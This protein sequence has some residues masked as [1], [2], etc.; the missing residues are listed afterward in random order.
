MAASDTPNS[1][2]PSGR[3][4]LL[5]LNVFL[6]AVAAFAIVVMTNYL[7]AGHF[8]RFQMDR[9]SA[10]KISPQTVRVLDSLTNNV[11]ITIFFAPHG[12]NEDLYGLVSGLLTEYQQSCPRHLR[13]KTLD[14]DRDVGDAKEFLTTNNITD[15]TRD[16]VFI[17][18]GGHSRLI[19]ARDLADYDF[20][21]LLAHRSKFVRRSAFLG[22]LYFTSAIYNVCNPQP[23]KAYFLWGN[24]ENDPAETNA[25]GGYSKLA[26]ILKDEIDCPWEK[27]SL[28]GTNEIPADCQLLIVPAGAREDTIPPQELTKMALYLKQGGRLF[29]LL[30]KRSGMETI[31]ADWG[32]GL[33]ERRA[34]DL[35]KR[36][37]L[38]Q[39]G[40][41]LTAIMAPHPIMNPL[42]SDNKAVEM[43]FPRP[44]YELED[45]SKI[46][47]GPQITA[48]AATS[49]QGVLLDLHNPTNVIREKNIPLLV[50]VEQG[51]ISG[52]NTAGGRGTRMVVAGD[53]DFL[54]NQVIDSEGNHDF[55]R[56]AL[57]WL[58]QRPQVMLADLGPRPIKE[59]K[60]HMTHAQEQMIGALFLA[61]MPGAVLLVGG[62][63]WL[64]RRN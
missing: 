56:L 61:G 12:D 24:G 3:R 60:L 36:F 37:S 25:A 19:Q 62:F 43:V 33:A 17:E 18:S 55:A 34:V 50:A 39:E 9:D 30:T 46:P 23:M 41:F 31:L 49:D 21:D 13:V 59:Y 20:S 53:S 48:L 58:L 15:K 42:I 40:V 45:H 51:T 1:G 64:R 10:F 63:V 52:V 35:D 47:G 54:D 28:N 32:V 22:E 6:G 8:K 2:F 26:A 5:W 27:L 44:V 7:A 29:A 4:W 38:G 57:N 11:N 16:F 14:Y